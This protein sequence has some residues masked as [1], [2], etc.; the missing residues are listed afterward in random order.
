M[1]SIKPTNERPAVRAATR[2][3][4]ANE[5]FYGQLAERQPANLDRP[6]ARAVEDAREEREAEVGAVD[7]HRLAERRSLALHRAIAERLRRDPSLLTAARA[8]LERWA[9][10]GEIHPR[11]GQAWRE[12]IAGPLEE[13]C[14][15]LGRDDERMRALRQSTPFAGVI[16]PRTRWR[17][18]AEVRDASPARQ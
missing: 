4:V 15:A 12:L 17:I 6:A 11:Y 13:L 7:P 18:W 2:T 9:A 14:A 3:T 10:S 1:K 5:K 8:R 16:D